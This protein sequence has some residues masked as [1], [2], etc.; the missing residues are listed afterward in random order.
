VLC[1][2]PSQY[3]FAIG[4]VASVLEKEL[5]KKTFQPLIGKSSDILNRKMQICENATEKYFQVRRSKIPRVE[6]WVEKRDLR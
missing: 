3:L 5:I 4:P 2:F 6:F 1:N